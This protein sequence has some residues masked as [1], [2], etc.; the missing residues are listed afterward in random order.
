MDKTT[1]TII[2]SPVEAIFLAGLLGADVLLGIRD[3]LLGWLDEEIE[4][5]WDQARATL[6]E[7]RFI[8]VQA[9]GGI[10]MDTTVA[11][12]VG[13]WAYPETSFLVTFTSAEG[14]SQIRSFHLT[15]NLGV[16]QVQAD[17]VVQLTVLEDAQAVYRRILEIFGLDD[18]SAAPGPGGALPEAYLMEARA[19]AM[20]MGKGAAL[21]ILEEAGLPQAAAESLAQTMARPIANGAL[22][23]LA[24]RTTT[25]E[26]DGLGL[27]RG[28]NGLW[29][30]RSF[31]C[32]GE[33]WV[34]VIPCD[35]A[36][37]RQEIRLVMNRVLPEPLA[38]E[39]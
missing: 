12:L 21:Q 29:H 27:L 26:V 36:R 9:D 23:A 18:Q 33:N 32:A 11:A 19:R 31:T 24:R 38:E 39:K 13:T 16:E 37:A 17:D 5:A 1:P 6:A 4:E 20:A 2:C 14:I 10:V 22:V 7:R 35:A 34:E 3:P 30:L 25:W 15:R 8:E 28:E